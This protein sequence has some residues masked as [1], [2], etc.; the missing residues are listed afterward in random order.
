MDSCAR[1]AP[2]GG[3]VVDIE[4]RPSAIEGFGLFALQP[5]SPGTR[6]RRVNV[7]REVTADQPLRPELGERWDHCDYPD[8]KV[9]L[10]GPPDHNLNHSCDPNAYLHYE[11]SQC[12]I[13]ARRQIAVGEEITCDYSI[14]LAGGDSWP[15]HCGAARCRGITTGDFFSLPEELQREYRPL[16]ADWFVAS[17]TEQLQHLAARS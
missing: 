15:C 7:V 6:I 13:V 2:E 8:G 5:C 17:H 9:V 4:V 10:V 12:F 1:M 14:N 16:L 3:E 11:G